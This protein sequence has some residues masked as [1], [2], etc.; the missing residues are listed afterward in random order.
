VGL[1]KAKRS[2]KAHLYIKIFSHRN[3]KS[4]KKFL[5]SFI[6]SKIGFLDNMGRDEGGKSDMERVGLFSE[7]GYTTLGDK[8]PKVHPNARPINQTAHKGKQMLPGGSKT[9]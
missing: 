5:H 3:S 9:M 8:Y 2:Y 1:K 7:V 6:L 4:E